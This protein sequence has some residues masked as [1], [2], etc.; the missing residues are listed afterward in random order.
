MNFRFSEDKNRQLLKTRGIT[1]EDVIE[2][3]A[4]NGVLAEFENPNQRTYPG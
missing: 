1:F 3:F 2:A 4:E